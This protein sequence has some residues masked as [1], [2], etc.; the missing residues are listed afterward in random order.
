MD[1]FY[2]M[3]ERSLAL[4]DELLRE[5]RVAASRFNI[6]KKRVD[7]GLRQYPKLAEKKVSPT[8]K[9]KY[10]KNRESPE[11]RFMDKLLR[12]RVSELLLRDRSLD[13]YYNDNQ[14]EEENSRARHLA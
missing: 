8:V 9:Y 14:L 2:R 4:N 12:E 11:P 1:T 3:M 5:A 13:Y 10:I 6:M 7:T